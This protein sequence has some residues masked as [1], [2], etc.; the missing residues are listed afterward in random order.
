MLKNVA[1]QKENHRW[2]SIGNW[3]GKQAPTLQKLLVTVRTTNAVTP[4]PVALEKGIANRNGSVLPAFD[5]LRRNQYALIP[6]E[7]KAANV[8]ACQGHGYHL[9]NGQYRGVV[10]A[11]K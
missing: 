10:I 4:Q 8:K 11:A 1:K 9:D 3:C 7:G 5:A 6:L 2:L